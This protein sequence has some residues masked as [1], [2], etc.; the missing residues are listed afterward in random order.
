MRTAECLLFSSRENNKTSNAR[1]FRSNILVKTITI[2]DAFT[3]DLRL[4]RPICSQETTSLQTTLTAP[5]Q[6]VDSLLASSILRRPTLAL[7]SVSYL[8]VMSS[9]ECGSFP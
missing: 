1:A 4:P 3:K 6:D 8:G 5:K 9:S 7:V 2:V